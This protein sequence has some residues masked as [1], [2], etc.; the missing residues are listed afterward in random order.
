MSV[1]LTL[2]EDRLFPAEPS[3]RAL[4][5]E[6]CG[7]VAR[8]PILIPHW[9]IDPAWFATNDPFGNAAIDLARTPPKRAYKL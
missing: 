6:R 2:H 9:H 4:A 8:P 3:V 5:R 7:E 1:P